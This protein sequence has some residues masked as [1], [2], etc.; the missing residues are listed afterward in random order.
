MSKYYRANNKR[1]YLNSR[2]QPD[3][4]QVTLQDLDYGGGSK[5]RNIPT[6]ADKVMRLVIWGIQY[7]NPSAAPDKEIVSTTWVGPGQVFDIIRAQEG[8]EAHEH[9]VGDNIALLLTAEMTREILI[10]EDFEESIAGSIA[11]TDDTDEDGEMEVIALPPDNEVSEEGYRKILVS[12]GVGEAP[13]WQ[14]AFATEVGA[15]KAI[16]PPPFLLAVGLVNKHIGAIFRENGEVFANLTS[17]WSSY[18]CVWYNRNAYVIE[19]NILTK[20]NL[21]GVRDT[22]FGQV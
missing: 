17:D 19:G 12:G 5:D 4:S 3:D 21:Y 9:F 22:S 14:F 13:Y 1:G 10:F 8:T 20:R 16:I 15:T 7:P 2:V 6:I 11:Y 18:S